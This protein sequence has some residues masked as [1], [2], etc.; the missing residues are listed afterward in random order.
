MNR[1]MRRFFVPMFTYLM[2]PVLT[3]AMSVLRLMP[4]F[5]AAS[6]GVIS[7]SAEFLGGPASFCR[8]VNPIAC[9]APL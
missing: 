7:I 2:F 8:K 4:S 3:C 9:A 1:Q 5:D 6:F